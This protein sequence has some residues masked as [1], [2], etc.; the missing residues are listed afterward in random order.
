MFLL[1][2]HDVRGTQ[3]GTTLEEK[4][5]AHTG[6]P[7]SLNKVV[8]LFFSPSLISRLLKTIRIG[9]HGSVLVRSR[10]CTVAVQF[11]LADQTCVSVPTADG[12][13]PV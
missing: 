12:G 4:A 9:M 13:Y 10:E 11:F 8:F 5:A 7:K 6:E 1:V 3:D 2:A